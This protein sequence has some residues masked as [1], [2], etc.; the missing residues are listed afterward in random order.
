MLSHGYPPIIS[1]VTLVTQKLARDMVRRGHR[2]TVISASELREPYRD[3]DEGVELVRVRSTRNPFWKGGPLPILSHDLLKELVSSFQPEVIHTHDTGMLALQLLRLELEGFI[4]QIATCHF[5]PRFVR[6]YIDMGE[7][8]DRFAEAITWGYAVRMINHFDHAVFP[9]ATQQ[10]AFASKGLAIPSTVISNGLDTARY[11]P[12]R[13]Y[14]PDRWAELPQGPRLLF[15][16][17]LAK[18]K[19]IELLIRAMPRI[20]SEIGGQLLLVGSGDDRQRLEQI[21]QDWRLDHCVHFLGFVPEVDLPALYREVNLFVIA[22]E[23]EVQ[24]IPTLQATASA[25]PV[26]AVK[27]GALPELAL[28]GTNGAL[29]A[30]NDADAFADAAIQI[31]SDPG[32]S[33]RFS[34]ASLKIGRYHAERRTFQAYEQLYFKVIRSKRT[35]QRIVREP[36]STARQLEA[37]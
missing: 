28:D 19:N 2:V 26:V 6:N 8:V 32:L 14:E 10:S 17:R 7:R 23:C 5:L 21:V 29:I 3:Q 12:M 30:P 24:S 35:S 15:V 27:A 4:P 25:L 37:S 20:S 18:D 1:G 36:I 11:R 33:A 22:S 31:L 34:H 16:G 13:G 9:T